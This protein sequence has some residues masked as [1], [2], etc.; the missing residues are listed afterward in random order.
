MVALA[1]GSEATR[2]VKRE[3]SFKYVL[4]GAWGAGG[5]KRRL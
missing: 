4:D 2:W 1:T 5:R 3:I